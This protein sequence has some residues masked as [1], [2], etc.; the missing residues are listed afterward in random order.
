MEYSDDSC[1]FCNHV[2]V[3]GDRIYPLTLAFFRWNVCM[4]CKDAVRSYIDAFIKKI[5]KDETENEYR[6]V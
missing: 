2:F 5:N 1:K 4:D 3:T 6:G